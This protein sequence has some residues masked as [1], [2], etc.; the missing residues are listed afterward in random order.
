MTGLSIASSFNA[1][2][3]NQNIVGG[4]RT[5]KPKPKTS[6]TTKTSKT[7]KT[8]KKYKGGGSDDIEVQWAD[9]KY[10]CTEKL[11][12]TITETTP[13][14]KE[15]IKLPEKTGGVEIVQ[16][17]DT[18]TE[19]D[20]TKA[21]IDD[22]KNK[23]NEIDSSNNGG[24]EGGGKK[25]KRKTSKNLT[26]KG[27]YKKALNRITL[28]RLQKLSLKH[29]IK[30]TTKKNGKTVNIKKASLINKLANIRYPKK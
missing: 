13:T 5:S 8:S 17:L 23:D 20:I 14:P 29:N 22:I 18:K 25:G 10:N 16:N 4:K 15:E 1:L 26:Q 11:P 2:F 24:Q 9:K 21:L 19:T 12:E 6:K 30:I 3:N 7:S 28:E 27:S